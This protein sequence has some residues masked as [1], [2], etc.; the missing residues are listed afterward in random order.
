MSI[1][2]LHNFHNNRN[3]RG[4]LANSIAIMSDA[5]HLLGDLLD[6]LILII[7][8]YKKVIIE[9]KESEFLLALY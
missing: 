7:S 3:N 9:Q 2:H 6:F 4:Y 8:I 1:C 5:T